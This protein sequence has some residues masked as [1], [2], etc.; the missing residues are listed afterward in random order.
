MT[1]QRAATLIGGTWTLTR[2]GERD[3]RITVTIT[4]LGKLSPQGPVMLR[5]SNGQAYE[6]ARHEV[7]GP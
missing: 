7:V 2:Y 3:S 5:A 6:A 4:G 1:D